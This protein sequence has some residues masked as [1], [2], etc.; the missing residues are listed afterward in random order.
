MVWSKKKSLLDRGDK[1]RNPH[2]GVPL[3]K[4]KIRE[5]VLK[6]RGNLT[7]VALALGSTRTNVRDVI[8]SDPELAKTLAEARER[9]VDEIEDSFLDKCKKGDCTSQIF[10]LKTRG[11]DRGY[12]QD[13]RADIEAVTRTALQWALNKSR[14][15]VDAQPAQPAIEQIQQADS[16]ANE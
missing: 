4:A 1:A 15:P 8:N 16:Q 2:P 10:F 9:V 13:F 12:D 11:R 5:L 6:H 3:D 14:S 7:K